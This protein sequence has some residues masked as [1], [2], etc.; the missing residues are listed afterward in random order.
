VWYFFSLSLSS[1][2]TYIGMWHLGVELVAE[3][4]RCSV[5]LQERVFFLHQLFAG[6]LSCG[7]VSAV[8]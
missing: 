1:F 2:F 5:L 7:G 8:F 3:H 4:F 6:P